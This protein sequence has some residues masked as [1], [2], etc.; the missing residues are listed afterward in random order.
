[1]W[2]ET[3]L[4]PGYAGLYGRSP[5]NDMDKAAA[6]ALPSGGRLW[7]PGRFRIS[8]AI[9]TRKTGRWYISFI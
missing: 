2:N 1:M 7:L 6:P 8:Q 3:A 4:M 9:W 5:D